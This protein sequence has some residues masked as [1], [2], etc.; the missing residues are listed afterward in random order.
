MSARALRIGTRASALA[1]WQ[2]RHVEALLRERPGA[3]PLELVHIRTSGDAQREVP[4]WQTEGRAFFTREIDEALSRGTIDVAV[5]S[6]KD[7]PTALAPGLTLAATLAREDPR[8][9]LL[10]RTGVALK[11]LPPGARIGTSSLRRR[12]FLARQRRDALPVELRGNVPTRIERLKGGDYDAIIL[13][14]AG[15]ARLG[16]AQHV[17]EHL[18]PEEFPPAVS[19]GVIGVCARADDAATLGLLRALDDRGAR[20]AVSAERA[21]LRR[22]EGGCQVPLGALAE[23]RGDTLI[24][25]AA[26]CAL[27]GSR[28]LRARGTATATRAAALTAAEAEALGERIADELLAAGAAALIAEDRASLAVTAP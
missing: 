20:L 13:A 22:L 24:L 19:Q 4:L 23:L 14:S 25:Q 9:A 12:A 11:E 15:L 1:L 6:L 8:D 17:T 10:T 2:A 5:H 3:P 16:L 7:L 26:V 21:L 18:S 27:D 28:E